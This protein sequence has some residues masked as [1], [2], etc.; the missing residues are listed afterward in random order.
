MA[1]AQREYVLEVFSDQHLVRDIVTGIL[2]TIFFHRYF[3]PIRPSLYAPTS[4]TSYSGSRS[5]E[6]LPVPL[7]AILDPPEVSAAI[8]THVDALVAQLT[9]ST[10][11][12][13]GSRGEIVIQLFDRKGRKTGTAANW[14]GRLGGTQ[15]EGEVCWEQWVL[16]VIVVSPRNEAERVKVRRA[17]ETSLQKAAMKIVALANRDKDHIPPISTSDQNPFPYKIT[18]TQ[19]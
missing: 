3:S 15:V 7:P 8:D 1:Q 10:S 16:Q 11:P 2:H 17:M 4:T 13:S 14:L 18:V 9:S 12:T 5:H 19:S 6:A